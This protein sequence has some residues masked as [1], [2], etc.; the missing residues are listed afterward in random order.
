[1]DYTTHKTRVRAMHTQ[2]NTQ[3]QRRVTANKTNWLWVSLSIKKNTKNNEAAMKRACTTRL[4]SSCS[5]RLTVMS[6]HSHQCRPSSTV[7]AARINE[8]NELVTCC[9]RDVTSCRWESWQSLSWLLQMLATQCSSLTTRQSKC[10]R[11]KGH[12][13]HFEPRTQQFRPSLH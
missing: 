12:C 8:Q 13:H 9:Q 4:R 2:A 11:V 7:A 5:S 10:Q 6:T 1:M 3:T